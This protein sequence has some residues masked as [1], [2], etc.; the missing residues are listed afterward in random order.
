MH[1][2]IINNYAKIIDMKNNL[3]GVIKKVLPAT[4][5]I[6]ISKDFNDLQKEA[7]S[8]TSIIPSVKNKKLEN[9]KN[10]ADKDGN[11]R[12]GSGSGFIVNPEGIVISNRHIISDQ[13][14]TYTV[15]ASD[16]K[17]YSA[18]V[19]ARDPISDIA[20][21]KIEDHNKLPFIKLGDSS[22]L[23][24]GEEVIAIG[25]A[26]GLFQNTVSAGIISGLSRSITAQID[27]RSPVQEIHG[28]IQ[29]DA[30]INPGN[31]GGPLVNM[32]GEAIGINIAIISSAENIGFTL[33]I[34]T[35][36]KD[37]EDFKKYG[38]IRR[39]FLGV[40]YVIID[41]R[42]KNKFKLPV[43]FG[44]YVVSEKP[45]G[46]I[47]IPK[48]PAEKAGIKEKDILLEINGKKITPEKTVGDILETCSVNDCK[49][50][51]ILRAGKE[52]ETEVTL[53]ERK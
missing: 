38:R 21:L 15:I 24:L 17:K 30:A 49:K 31:S 14:S 33:P 19:I 36:K 47:I 5:T 13:T 22:K 1:M 32:K 6:I 51:K 41:E 50:I 10:Q 4:V 12:I 11:V 40:H 26:M 3:V 23:E 52:F 42:I 35:V 39:P 28:L 7:K 27:S 45:Y 16:G 48:S 43:D 18:K 9:L 8:I 44:A 29:T 20:M 34:N 53:G 2:I 25:N 37:L 46:E